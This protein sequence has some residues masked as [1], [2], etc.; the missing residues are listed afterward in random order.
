MTRT[1]V[2]FFVAIVSLP[3]T[4][5]PGGLA[6]ALGAE[7]DKATKSWEQKFDQEILPIVR[8]RCLECHSGDEPDGGF[9]IAAFSSGELVTKKIDLWDEVGKRVRLREMP[10]EGSPQ[11]NDEQKSKFH[12]WLDQRPQQDL[13]SQLA[14]DETQAWYRG[15]VM[16]RRLTRTEYL[17]AIGDLVGIPADPDL[18]I[19]SD[20]SGGEGFDTNGDSLFTSAIHIEQ[21]V[22]IAS[23]AI[24]TVIAASGD[25]GDPKAAQLQAA[26]ETL[27]V[28]RPG[29]ALSEVDAAKAVVKSFARRAWRRPVH[30]DEVTRLMSLYEATRTR[31]AT[32]DQAVGEPL[33]AILVSPNFLFVVESETPEGGVQRLTPHQLATRLALFIWSSVPDDELLSHADNGTLDTNEQVVAQVRRMLA[34]PKAQALGENF[35]MQWLGLASF[36]TTVRPDQEVYPEYSESLSRDLHHE[37]VRLIS[38]VFREDRSLL[39]LIDSNYVEVNG[40]LAQHYQL[41]LPPDAPWQTLETQDRRRGGVVTLGAALMTASYPRRTSPV[42]RGRWVLEQV[43]GSQVPPPPP[44]VPALEDAKVEK[45]MTLRERLEVHRQNPDC[46][47]CHNRMDP[48]GFGLENFDGLGRW[49]ETDAGL[50]IDSSGKLPSGETFEGPEQL[51]QI[52]LKRAGEFER[53][54]VKKLLGFAL[55]RDLNKFDDCVIKDCLERLKA[56]EH[57]ASAVIE[58]IAVSYPFQHRYFK[59]AAKAE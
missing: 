29:D 20:G 5:W 22:A 7:D 23:K 42:L 51:K 19:P 26:R 33:K 25:D 44:N 2:A 37:A 39:D 49:R 4:L 35:G 47:S 28:S 17:N 48:L 41:D 52:L 59:A 6:P 1:R 34:D 11:L 36:L 3:L 31:G 54:F 53:H 18:E 9:D 27:L 40:A 12:R 38:N 15:Y 46:A 57:R 21:Y 45:A 13:C 55:G 14:T 50:A 8:D 32:W 16:S 30:D 24:D 56:E 10:P 58:T 43:L